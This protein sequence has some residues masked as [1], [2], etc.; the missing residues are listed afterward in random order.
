MAI[1]QL[2]E[3]DGLDIFVLV[4]NISDPFTTSD[5]GIHW[6]EMQY[7]HELRKQETICGDDY[8]RACNGLSLFIRIKTPHKTYTMLLDTGPD[9]NLAVE[10]AKR[11]QLN[12]NDVEA[13]VLSHGH[14]DHYGGTIQI[15]NAIQKRNLPVYTHPELFLPRAFGEKNLVYVSYTLTNEMVEKAGG[16]II[17]SAGPQL[18]FDD[19]ALISGEV[20]RLTAYEKGMPDE[21]RLK[22]KDWQCEPGVIDERCLLFNIK[23]KG[24]CVITGCGHTGIVNATTHA[25][26]LLNTQQVYFVMGGFHLASPELFNRID[27]TLQDLASIN[28]NYIISGHCTGRRTQAKLSEK[29]GSR[30]IPYGVG[31]VLN[32]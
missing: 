25:M 21:H 8:C 16:T 24:L 3:I 19:Y 11:L 17:A 2:K 10:N 1:P 30:H 5:T 29:F 20:P 31:A 18:L 14:F 28:P 15:L 4:D 7:R 26:N 13:I 27:P 6:N 12:L 9:R 22:N 32:V 23:N